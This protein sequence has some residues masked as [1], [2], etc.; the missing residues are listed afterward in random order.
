M[1]LIDP[2]FRREI[3]AEKWRRIAGRIT[4]HPEFLAIALGN[5][6]RWLAAGRLHPSPLLD[7]KKR[8]LAAQSDS[9]GFQDL[10][11]FLESDASDAETLKSCSPFVSPLFAP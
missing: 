4:Q 11:A 2:H 6:D 8:I 3:P 7:W 10:I 9:S 5:I 1:D